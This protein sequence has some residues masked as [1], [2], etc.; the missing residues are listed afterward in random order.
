MEEIHMEM[1]GVGIAVCGASKP[2]LE[3]PPSSAWMC[4]PTRSSSDGIAQDLS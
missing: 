4:S 1:C 3:T 2:L